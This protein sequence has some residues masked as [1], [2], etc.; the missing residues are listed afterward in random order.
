MDTFVRYE[1]LIGNDGASSLT[2][3]RVIDVDPESGQDITGEARNKPT[4]VVN[5]LKTFAGAGPINITSTEP[6]RDVLSCFKRA[7]RA[8]TQ[9][10]GNGTSILISWYATSLPKVE[11][12][13]S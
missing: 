1:E 12:I 6:V 2:R 13:W 11:P 5:S 7:R 8:I 10:I 4:P 9:L 3:S